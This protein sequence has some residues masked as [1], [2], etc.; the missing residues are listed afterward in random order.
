M[1][2]GFFHVMKAKRY[3]HTVVSCATYNI[4]DNSKAEEPTVTTTRSCFHLRGFQRECLFSLHWRDLE[5]RQISFPLYLPWQSLF[6]SYWNPSLLLLFFDLLTLLLIVHDGF[7]NQWRNLLFFFHSPMEIWCPLK[8]R[9]EDT[10]YGFTDHLYQA[11]YDKGY[12]TFID[13][14]LQRGEE[15]S[16]ELLKA[17]ELSMISIIIFS[18]NYAYSTWCLDELVRIL[19]CRKNG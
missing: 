6:A 18:K 19:E 5:W 10:C 14:N 11:L 3:C 2:I 12:S 17:I 13:D 15:I 1:F 9:G 4:F 8:F 7:P 16:V